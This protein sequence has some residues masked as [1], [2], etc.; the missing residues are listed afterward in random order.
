M[1]NRQY[2]DPFWQMLD[3]DIEF[4]VPARQVDIKRKKRKSAEGIV[5]NVPLFLG[6]M[7][8]L[9]ARHNFDLDRVWR[10]LLMM[11]EIF[12]DIVDV[13]ELRG[14]NNLDIRRDIERGLK[15]RRLIGKAA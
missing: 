15:L 1:F 9:Y 4:Q 6:N 3:E 11:D 8:S 5:R 12:D 10:D 13:Y 7:I 14:K 2:L